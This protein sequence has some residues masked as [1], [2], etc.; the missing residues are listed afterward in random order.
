[1]YCHTC[2]KLLLLILSNLKQQSYEGYHSKPLKL[3][4]NLA[5]LGLNVLS[6]K[7]LLL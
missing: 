6:P 7:N 2:A 3:V 4:N 1:M 5:V